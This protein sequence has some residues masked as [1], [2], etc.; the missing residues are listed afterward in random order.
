M[1]KPSERY[2]VLQ[3]LSSHY[4]KLKDIQPSKKIFSHQFKT[5]DSKRNNVF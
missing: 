3:N 1:T 4:Q 2:L 5:I